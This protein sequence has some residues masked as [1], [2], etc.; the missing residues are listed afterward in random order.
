MSF[1]NKSL[2]EAKDLELYQWEVTRGFGDKLSSPALNSSC[3]EPLRLSANLTHKIHFGWAGGSPLRKPSK[4]LVSSSWVWRF[5]LSVWA[6]NFSDLMHPLRAIIYLKKYHSSPSNFSTTPPLSS[7]FPVER[8]FW[9]C[10]TWTFN[11]PNFWVKETI[12][13]FW[14]KKNPSILLLEVQTCVGTVETGVESSQKSENRA[15]RTPRSVVLFLG[16][17]AG[18]I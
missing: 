15:T 14:E 8:I 11:C 2:E 16:S 4:H 12:P 18:G 17:T 13:D 9:K 6:A 10:F 7:K 1:L 3:R 5:T